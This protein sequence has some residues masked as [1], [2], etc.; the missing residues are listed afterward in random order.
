VRPATDGVRI[1]YVER[2]GDHYDLMQISVNGGEPQRMLAP[3]PNSLIWDVSPDGS[4]YLMTSFT[5]RG[6]PSPLWSWPVT[7]GP[8]VRFGD[9]VSGSASWS[10]D[11]KMI[12]GHSGHDL[13][14]ANADGSSKRVI[15]SFREEPDSPVWSPDGTRIRFTLNDP[16]RDLGTI[17]E[18]R[19]DGTG[20]RSV[21]PGWREP[22]R[23]CCG[24][25]TPDGRY[26]IFVDAL[27]GSRLWALREHGTWW[28]RSPRG[29]FLLAD[30]ANGTWSP[31]VGKDGRHIYFY[32]DSPAGTLERLDIASSQSTPFLPEAHLPSMPAFSRDGQWIAYVQLDNGIVWRSRPDGRERSQVTPPAF[33][34]SFPR[35]SPDG[36]ML[37]LASRRPGEP[38]NA[39]LI[40]ADGGQPDPLVP[41]LGGLTDPDWSPDGTSVVVSRLLPSQPGKNA[42]SMLAIVNVKTR[43]LETIS[44]SEYL[45]MP[46]WSPDG[47]WIAAVN[48]ARGELDLYNARTKE[49]HTAARGGFFSLPSW[50]ADALHLYYQDLLAPG[51][52]VFRVNVA[53]NRIEKV[54]DFQ[55]LFAS[56]IHRCPFWGL[57]PDGSAIIALQRG[58]AD[59]H[60]ATV[61]LP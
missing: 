15:A 27:K 1:F 43:A 4:Q 20:L 38:A 30:E 7:G 9:F 26:F 58:T 45:S 31:L 37:A 22:P 55:R 35:W 16:D 21:L 33:R 44:G 18:I 59:I 57:A 13:L 11:G 60:A 17:W 19:S 8:P 40:S 49:W 46:R 61:S 23:L 6:E 12:A 47:G 24:T 53:S 39:Y 54:T 36:R 14:I 34:G 29:P 41:G 51:E 32:S 52:P 3:F 2:N 5:H 50:S 25:W 56:G 48:N 28:R 10:P 42:D